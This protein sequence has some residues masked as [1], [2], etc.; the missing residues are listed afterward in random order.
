MSHILDVLKSSF[1]F[2]IRELKGMFSFAFTFITNK[3]QYRGKVR[4]NMSVTIIKGSSFEGSDSLGDHTHFCGSMGYG[5]YMMQNSYFV[6]SIGRFT[7][8]GAE[9]MNVQGVHPTAAPFATTS[10]MFYSLKKQTMTTFAERQMFNE[11]RDPIKIGNDCWIG[12]RVFAVGGLTI[13]DGAVVLSGS[14]LTKDVP[15]YAIVGGVPA[16]II[17][18]RYDDDTI[19]FLLD[20]KWWDKPLPW[21]KENWELLCDINK[22]KDELKKS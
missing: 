8:I 20:H 3:M 6:G 10:P 17:S 12:C 15:P 19:K 13:S 2:V 5:S 7:S 1:S 18:Y 9:F 11:M 21:L 16:K 14:V 4:Y 22:L